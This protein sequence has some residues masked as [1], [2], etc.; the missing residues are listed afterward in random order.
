MSAGSL[1]LVVD[2]YSDNAELLRLW[3]GTIGARSVTANTGTEALEI[4]KAHRPTAG[5]IDLKLQDTNGFQIA[6]AFRQSPDPAVRE[7]VLVAYTGLTGAK[8][9]AE[10]LAAGFDYYVIKPCDVEVLAACLGLS[11]VRHLSVPNVD[12]AKLD[13]LSERS[14]AAMERARKLVRNYPF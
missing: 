10:C 11:D 3:L 1:T 7:A 13:A 8:Y 14:R 6:S 12:H 4:I 5:I 2:D 9:R